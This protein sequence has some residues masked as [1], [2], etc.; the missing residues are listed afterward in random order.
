MKA[1]RTKTKNGKT[2]SYY[3]VCHNDCNRYQL[4][5]IPWKRIDDREFES[6]ESAIKM[7]KDIIFNA[8][9]SIVEECELSFKAI[10]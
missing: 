9:G 8:R 1:Y 7:L 4:I 5:A 10:I 6:E 2:E 3:L